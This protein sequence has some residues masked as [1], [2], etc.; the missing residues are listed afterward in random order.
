MEFL[1]CG[2]LNVNYLTHSNWRL[3]L[4]V[5]LQTYNMAQSVDIP[6][7]I[8]KTSNRAIYNIFA[9]YT[10]INSFKISLRSMVYLITTHKILF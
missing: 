6:T 7:R 2:D 10:R 8:H 5:L 9:D 3:Q 4:P 1:L